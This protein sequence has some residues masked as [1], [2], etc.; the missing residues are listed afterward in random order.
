MKT[1]KLSKLNLI[2]L[3]ACVDGIDFAKRFGFLDLEITKSQ[4]D[5]IQYNKNNS[6]DYVGYLEFIKATLLDLN[7]NYVVQNKNKQIVQINNNGTIYDV[8]Y[9][10]KQLVFSDYG[11]VTK[12]YDIETNQ[13]KIIDD[14]KMSLFDNQ[15]KMYD[16]QTHYSLYDFVVV[17]DT[18]GNT[19]ITYNGKIITK[20]SIYKSWIINGEVDGDK[21]SYTIKLDKENIKFESTNEYTEITNYVYNGD[22]LGFEI[23]YRYDKK[24]NLILHNR[25]TKYH[26]INTNTTFV[27]DDDK[28]QKIIITDEDRQ[29]EIINF[30]NFW[31]SLE[32]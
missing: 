30:E 27:Y 5:L 1:L 32:N 6:N 9:L 14:L 22:E 28:I 26:I 17:I 4:F 23:I 10:S 7:R 21:K 20:S 19:Y 8:T 16:Y 29:D 2:A 31:K 3:G 12:I 11:V 24:G 15:T 25:K 13:T 18:S